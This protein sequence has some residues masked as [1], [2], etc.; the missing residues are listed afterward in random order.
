M[1][2]CLKSLGVKF[3][4]PVLFV[5]RGWRGGGGLECFLRLP[6]NWGLPLSFGVVFL[7]YNP[8]FYRVSGFVDLP[9]FSSLEPSQPILS[10]SVEV[11]VCDGDRS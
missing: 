3:N 1:E 7:A 6:V 9:C 2:C 10:F 4:I 8:F 5:F 11:G